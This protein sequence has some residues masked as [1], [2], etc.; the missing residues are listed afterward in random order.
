MTLSHCYVHLTNTEVVMNKG[1]FL[2]INA[3]H[4]L[5]QF[6]MGMN[7]N[8]LHQTEKFLRWKRYYIRN[9]ITLEML[10]NYKYHYI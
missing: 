9:V 2:T 8:Y 10:L 7:R 5:A 3:L 1:G 4:L 6:K